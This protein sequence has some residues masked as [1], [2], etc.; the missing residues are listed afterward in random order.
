MP[1]A[2]LDAALT[3]VVEDCVNAVGVDV[4]TASASLLSYVAG[5]GP[6]LAKSIVVHRE[7]NGPFAT[8]Q[9]LMEVPR[10]G[11]KAFEQAAGFLRIPNGEEMLDNTGVH[12]ESYRA[13]RKLL[14]IC[15]QVTDLK[16]EIARRG[17]A[18]VAQEIEVG[19][20]Y[21]FGHRRGT[22]EAG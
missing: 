8:R 1:P 6:S 18:A 10:F 12:P 11:K 15:P 14:A 2:R 22:D 5:I 21:P 7:A 4:N 17:S 16:A 9:K 3:G 19:Y 20:S 13:A